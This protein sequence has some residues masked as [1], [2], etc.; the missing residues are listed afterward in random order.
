M[1]RR[2]GTRGLRRKPG[3]APGRARRISYSTR[4]TTRKRAL[5]AHHALISRRG[6]L[7]RED[8]VHRGDTVL[9]AEPQ[10]V[11]RVDARAGVPA[12]HRGALAQQLQRI[13]RERPDPTDHE[14]D[15]VRPRPPTMACIAAA[16]VTVARIARAPPSARSAAAGSVR[17]L[18]M[19]SCAPSER[20]SDSLS[21]PR[22]T[23]ATRNPRR[24]ANWTPRC[25]RPPRRA[26]RPVRR[27]ARRCD[28]AR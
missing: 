17:A 9:P 7:E 15:A 11:F 18:S 24:A 28:A 2:G 10:C 21:A 14:Q 8:L 25:P 19:Y 13:D 1:R 16:S 22:L 27:R 3:H 20:A 5:T 26:P 12:L 23:A 6:L 4:S